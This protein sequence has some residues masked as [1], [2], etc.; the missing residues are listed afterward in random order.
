MVDLVQGDADAGR[1]M[2]NPDALGDP[3]IGL[4]STSPLGDSEDPYTTLEDGTLV[5]S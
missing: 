5:E 2:D 4:V 3:T 1:L